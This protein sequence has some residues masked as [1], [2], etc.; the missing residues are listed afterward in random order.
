MPRLHAQESRLTREK[1]LNR[2]CV[3]LSSDECPF[4]A[5]LYTVSKNKEETSGSICLGISPTGVLVFEVRQAGEIN[6]IATFHWCT[7]MKLNADVIFFGKSFINFQNLN[8]LKILTEE[9]VRDP[10]K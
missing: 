5:H 7:V 10:H 2:F 9:K 3:E 8:F 1:A 6:L 4:N